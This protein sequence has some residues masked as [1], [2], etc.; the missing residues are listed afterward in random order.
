MPAID[1]ALAG[2]PVT[3]AVH[4]CFG[5]AALVGAKDR[6][7]YDFLGELSDSPAQ[8][9]SIEE[10]SRASTSASCPS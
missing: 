2:L 3:T 1:R 10:R 8:Q 6:N 4:L 5:Y 7:R 9:I